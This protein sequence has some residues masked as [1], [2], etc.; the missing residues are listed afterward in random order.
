MRTVIWVAILVAVGIVTAVFVGFD[1][2]GSAGTPE[3]DD[4]QSGLKDR[5]TIK[6]SHVYSENSP[7]GQA[8][9]YFAKRVEEK[10]DRQVEVEIYPNAVLYNEDEQL[11][12]LREGNVQMIAP[13]TSELTSEYPLFQ[14]LDLPFVYT[15]HDLV[16]EAYQGKIGTRLLKETDDD[17]MKGMDFWFGGYKQMTTDKKFVK[18]PSDFK[19]MHFGIMES[20]IIKSQFNIFGASTS[21]MNFNRLYRDLEVNFIEGQ[22][23]TVSNIYTR[24]LY[25]VQDYLTVSNHAIMSNIILINKDTWKG[26]PQ[27]IQTDINEAMSETTDWISRHAIEINDRQI[28]QLKRDK[29]IAIH[30]LTKD[31][32]KAWMETLTP[33]YSNL[34]TVI[35]KE[36][37]D[38]IDRIR[39]Q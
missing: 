18:Y 3:F 5:I 6:F 4:E 31:E 38:E 20:P 16:K 9:R 21:G 37:V 28:R 33:I 26:L 10:T 24:K 32:R 17:R 29:A 25:Q 27:N 13:S 19:R 22:E 1:F 39:T 34:E 15:N 30:L 23:N 12:A 11:S 7:Q 8:A 35:G 36:L 2:S 14:V